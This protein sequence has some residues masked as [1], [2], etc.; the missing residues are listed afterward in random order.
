LVFLTE[1]IL[2]PSFR[3]FSYRGEL[4]PL[5]HPRFSRPL[6]VRESPI[7][8][9]DDTLPDP[10]PLQL[11]QA[12]P[13][14]AAP[15]LTMSSVAGRVFP[16]FSP[17]RRRLRSTL[18]RSGFFDFLHFL[19]LF[20]HSFVLPAPVLRG[21]APQYTFFHGLYPSDPASLDA[22]PPNNS[23]SATSPSE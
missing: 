20:S 9:S 18:P 22:Q 14:S 23:T 4:W 2:S 7:V 21:L 12:P 11:V 17:N 5:T 3:S 1:P 10:S 13:S 16:S 15:L 19:R 6:F 8:E